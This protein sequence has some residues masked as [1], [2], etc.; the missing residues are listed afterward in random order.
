MQTLCLCSFDV[1]AQAK[2]FATT[3]F[4]LEIHVTNCHDGLTNEIIGSDEKAADEEESGR[5]AIV[6]LEE[7]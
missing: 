1:G 4:F 3:S 5:R 6:K 2:V 7:R